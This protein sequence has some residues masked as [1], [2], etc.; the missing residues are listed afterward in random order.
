MD[1]W[2]NGGL[3]IRVRDKANGMK[4]EEKSKVKER[5]GEESVVC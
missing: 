4:E 5:E 3:R 2:V 1:L